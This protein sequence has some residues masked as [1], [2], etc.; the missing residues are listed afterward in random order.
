MHEVNIDGY[1][2]VIPPNYIAGKEIAGIYDGYKLQVE[3]D[4]Y[5]TKI[6]RLEA[7]FFK[8]PERKLIGTLIYNPETSQMTLYKFVEMDKHHFI[9]GDEFGICNDIIK[10]LRSSD[11]IFI[12]N[13]KQNYYISVSKALKV[14]EYKHFKDAE[15]QLFIKLDDFKCKDVVT[16]IKR[17]RKK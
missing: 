2:F 10:H 4:C 11:K 9:K 14:G 17:K 5:T 12:S 13:G 16:K 3:I 7:G 8:T 1:N 6:Y 15:L